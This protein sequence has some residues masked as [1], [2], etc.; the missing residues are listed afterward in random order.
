M[1]SSSRFTPETDFS[2]SFEAGE[3]SF[4]V[5]HNLISFVLGLHGN[6]TD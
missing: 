4:L 1:A 6:R 5:T 2:E 3:N